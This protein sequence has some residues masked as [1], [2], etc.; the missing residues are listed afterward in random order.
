MTLSANL[1]DPAEPPDLLRAYLPSTHR[2]APVKLDSANRCPNCVLLEV[3]YDRQLTEFSTAA[4]LAIDLLCTH[5][6]EAVRDLLADPASDPA[7]LL[8]RLADQHRLADHLRNE[9]LRRITAQRDA[10][11][12]AV[13][14]LANRW[15]YQPGNPGRDG[16]F[17]WQGLDDGSVRVETVAEAENLCRGTVEVVRSLEEVRAVVEAGSRRADREHR[18][19][20]S[21]LPPAPWEQGALFPE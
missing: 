6:P 17:P 1:P 20:P 14:C 4:T 8:R 18:R 7:L 21:P 5:A 10:L 15:P 16:E 3:R 12:Y 9:A 11:L 2:I 13:A 19:R